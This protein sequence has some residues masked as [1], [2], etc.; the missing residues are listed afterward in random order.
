VG[1]VKLAHKALRLPL[2]N[3]RD[4]AG[5]KK[6]EV[7]SRDISNLR[8]EL[9][10]FICFS[11]FNRQVVFHQTPPATLSAHDRFYSYWRAFG[12]HPSDLTTFRLLMILVRHCL[13]SNRKANNNHHSSSFQMIDRAF[14]TPPLHSLTILALSPSVPQNC[15]IIMTL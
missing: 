10:E 7:H 9:S 14:S 11:E 1:A 5:F 3:D 15:V 8:K 13:I 6:A 4:G 2:T 12:G